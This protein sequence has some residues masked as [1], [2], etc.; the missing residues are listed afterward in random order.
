M[1]LFYVR[2]FCSFEV[3]EAKL[4][5]FGDYYNYDDVAFILHNN[6]LEGENQACFRLNSLRLKRLLVDFPPANRCVCYTTMIC[7]NAMDICPI[8]NRY[9]YHK[10]LF[11]NQFAVV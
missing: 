10:L 5:S 2:K 3:I 11:K 4:Q 1:F 9:Y 7:E 8:N 6:N